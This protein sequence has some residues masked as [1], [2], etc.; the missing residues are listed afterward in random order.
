MVRTELVAT[1]CHMREFIQFS[2]RIYQGHPLYVPHLLFE[3]GRFFSSSNPRFAFTDVAYFLAR[4]ATGKVTGRV[5]A[6]VNRRHNEAAGE[7]TG[8]FGFFECVPD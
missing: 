6:H 4:D 3:R 8:F 2:L 7:R 5:S 1:Q